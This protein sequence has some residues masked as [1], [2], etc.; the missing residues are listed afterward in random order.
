MQRANNDLN[1]LIIRFR[2]NFQHTV[3]MFNLCRK[4]NY[5]CLL[6]LLVTFHA[7][8][9]AEITVKEKKPGAK[10]SQ[11]V[12]KIVSIVD[13][14]IIMISE[15]NNRVLSIKNRLSRQGTPLPADDVVEQRVL[16]QLILESIQLQ[17]AT[18][19]GIR[20]PDEQLNETLENI[21]KGN[22]M[23][24]EQFEAQLTLE[25]ESYTGAREQ[26]RREIILSRI[27]KREVDRRVRVTEQEVKNFLASKEGRTHS[28]AEYLIG[29]ILVAL[30]ENAPDEDVKKAELR[31]Q[32][33]LKELR[34]GEDFSKVAVAKSDGRQALEGGIIG[35]RKETELPTIAQ[36][37]I[38]SLA[39][40]EPSLPIRT[41]SGF[42]IVSVLEKRGG[43]QQLV[44]Q[45]KVRHILIAPSTIRTDD[46]AKEIIDKL[47]ERIM[48]GDEFAEIARSNSDDPVSAIDGGSLDW[49]TP[50]QMVPEF[51]QIMEQTKVGQYSIP[52]NSQ[53]GWHVLQ[54]QDRRTE[55]MGEMIQTNQ[56]QQVLHRRKYEEELAHWL[57]E[58]KNEA[59]I[60][61]KDPMHRPIED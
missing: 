47:Y 43:Q 50:G 2:M 35:W 52:F 12:D 5:F 56:A 17:M 10:N 39:V 55:D 29:H 23:T 58:I 61:I 3:S 20:V 30:A 33:I 36:D 6:A 11:L 19:A 41:A 28:G 15:L 59:F 40:K 13:D 38:P 32:S 48:G 42:H 45:T 24:I 46:E 49:V 54:V 37:I 44:E 8:S 51:E 60:D 21:A 34:A 31:A 27:Q 25:G 9:Y 57:L 18:R 26:I 22:N 7:S 14:D 53:Y 16:D 4:V 1:S